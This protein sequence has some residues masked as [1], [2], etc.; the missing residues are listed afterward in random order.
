MIPTFELGDESGLLPWKAPFLGATVHRLVVVVGLWGFGE[1]LSP[2]GRRLLGFLGFWVFGYLDVWVFGGIWVYGVWMFQ[3]GK[4][5]GKGLAVGST[6]C[7]RREDS[8]ELALQ[9]QLFEISR[10]SSDDFGKI[11]CDFGSGSGPDS[12]WLYIW[13]AWYP[14]APGQF[15]RKCIGRTEILIFGKFENIIYFSNFK[16]CL[17]NSE[18]LSEES[19]LERSLRCTAEPEWP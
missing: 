10:I 8:V 2:L 7:T 9:I 13:G 11:F 5:L 17:K 18:I 16:F 4:G 3:V 12:R 14:R 19:C 1:L 6:G 15:C